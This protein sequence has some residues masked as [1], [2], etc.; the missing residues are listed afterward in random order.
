[1]S[2]VTDD[3]VQQDVRQHQAQMAHLLRRLDLVPGA[4]RAAGAPDVA[5]I[6][7]ALNDSIRALEAELAREMWRA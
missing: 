6:A 7:V 2:D 5:T 4:A 3:D 1:L